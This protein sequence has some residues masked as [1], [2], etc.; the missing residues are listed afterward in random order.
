MPEK[1]Q[2]LPSS[3]QAPRLKFAEWLAMR[4]RKSP[5]SKI[6]AAQK[7]CAAAGIAVSTQDLEAHFLCGK[8][9][10]ILAD[11]LAAA[12]EFGIETTFQRMAAIC[13]AV[14]DPMKVL[15][16]ASKERFAKFETFSPAGNDR[17]TGFTRDQRQVTA[18]I[19][20]IYTLSPSQVAFN[21]N[22]RNI[23]ERLGAAASVFINTTPDMRT[24]HLQKT[25]HE[26]E[27]KLIALELLAGLKSL[28][29]EYR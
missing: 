25:S 7:K 4:F 2:Q 29:I 21:F 24:L 16:E 18:T 14:H 28:T 20:I 23:H 9:P 19:T 15:L 6:R 26:A 3:V 5:V 13:L 11:A 8:D 1:N 22:L 27:L 12:K 10:M 17:I